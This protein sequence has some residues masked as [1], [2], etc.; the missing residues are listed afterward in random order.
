MT[1]KAIGIDI[2]SLTTKAVIMEN[3]SVLASALVPSGDE[4]ET[5]ARAALDEA[6]R[7]AGISLN[8]DACIVTTGLNA[9]EITF[10]DQQKAITTCLARGVAYR[11]PSARLIVDIGA[12]SSTVVKINDRGRVA[13]WANH[14]KCAAGTG[15]FLQQMAKL[16][17]VPLQEMAEI[18]LNAEKGADITPTCAVFAESE[19]ISHIH[20]V[21]PTPKAEI[22]LGIFDSVVSRIMS[23]CKR[24]GIAREVAMTGGVALNRGIVHALERELGF[25]VLIAEEP[26]F[27]AAAGAAVL[28]QEAI[29]KGAIA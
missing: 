4:A 7:L 19:V 22:A 3:G 16:M 11:L 5:S 28:A 12:E 13:D 14:D 27:V 29:D 23:M 24:V 8:G 15:L 25:G 10:K 17:E 21:P 26:Q 18:S 6:T 2:G 9:K 1:K 20:R